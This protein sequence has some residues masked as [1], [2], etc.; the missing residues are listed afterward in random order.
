MKLL[1][2]IKQVN[3][4]CESDY[5]ILRLP[6]LEVK[7]A[8]HLLKFAFAFHEVGAGGLE[9]AV[10]GVGTQREGERGCGDLSHLSNALGLIY[11]LAIG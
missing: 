11:R 5:I 9:C 10:V 6:K 4:G 8:I 7:G 2:A 1:Y 3:E